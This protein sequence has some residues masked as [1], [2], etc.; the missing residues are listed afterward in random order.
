[1]IRR[2][3]RSTQ[4]VSSAASDVYKRQGE[5]RMKQKQLMTSAHKFA[6]ESLIKNHI[7][8]KAQEFPQEPALRPLPDPELDIPDFALP[9]AEEEICTVPQTRPVSVVL[10]AVKKLFRIVKTRSQWSQTNS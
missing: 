6:H 2:P 7:G 5:I 1:M 3:P 10:L 8:M 9:P 4:G